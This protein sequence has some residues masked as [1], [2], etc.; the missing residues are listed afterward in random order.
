MTMT[1]RERA[2]LLAAQ[3]GSLV[4]LA[5]IQRDVVAARWRTLGAPLLWIERGWQI[6]I[7][8][9]THP[10]A[11]LLPAT[12]VVVFRPRWGWRIGGALV[13]LTRVGRWL[14]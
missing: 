13:A 12:A 14:R 10:W 5:Q 6:W 9:R 11:V 7:F 1:R 2:A 3:R 4:A 8:A